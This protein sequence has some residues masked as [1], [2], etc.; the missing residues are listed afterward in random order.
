MHSE[1]I[2]AGPVAIDRIVTRGRVKVSVETL[3]HVFRNWQVG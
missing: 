2:V 3:W 1:I